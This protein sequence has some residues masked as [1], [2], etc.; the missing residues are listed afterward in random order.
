MHAQ[1]ELTR[2]PSTNP[3]LAQFITRMEGWLLDFPQLF[4]C[5]WHK[6]SKFWHVAHGTRGLASLTCTAS[7]KEMWAC[8]SHHAWLLPRVDN[9][10]V[11][12]ASKHPETYRV[13][14]RS[15][16][17]RLGV[18]CGVTRACSSPLLQ[19]EQQAASPP[20]SMATAQSGRSKTAVQ[21]QSN[22][23]ATAA[24]GQRAPTATALWLSWHFPCRHCVW[25]LFS[26]CGTTLAAFCYITGSDLPLF[27][28]HFANGLSN[29]QQSCNE[30]F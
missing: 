15:P 23:S 11:I 19:E 20:A 14:S 18:E 3:S 12:F 17:N 30:I 10:V 13:D 8:T 9:T 29:T 4:G 5:P 16:T 7:W 24:A 26:T 28:S 6:T 21:P 25:R 2:L 1:I 22:G 27:S